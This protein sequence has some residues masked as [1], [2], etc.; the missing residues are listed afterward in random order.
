MTKGKVFFVL[1]ISLLLSNGLSASEAG[2]DVLALGNQILFD[3]LKPDDFRW[4]TALVAGVGLGAATGLIGF[5]EDV[6][7]APVLGQVLDKATLGMVQKED[8]VEGLGLMLGI[9]GI[10]GLWQNGPGLRAKY[11]SSFGLLLARDQLS[12]PGVVADH[13]IRNAAVGALGVMQGIN[14]MQNYLP[15]ILGAVL[16]KRNND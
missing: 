8:L 14:F 11:L 7:N 3:S 4:Q 1:G 16:P 13:E 12:N 5:K 15:G 2:N 6:S 9:N 10:L